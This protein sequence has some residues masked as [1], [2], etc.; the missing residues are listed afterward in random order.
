MAGCPDWCCLAHSS[1]SPIS[2]EARSIEVPVGFGEDG[3]Q[4]FE[5]RAVQYLTE[6]SGTTHA[7]EPVPFVEF[8]HHVN[9]RYSLINMSTAQARALVDALLRSIDAADSASG[10]ERHQR[11]SSQY[12]GSRT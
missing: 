1:D 6:D 2:H 8:A 12:S 3:G 10:T 5:V 11:K 9:G 4:F 7:C